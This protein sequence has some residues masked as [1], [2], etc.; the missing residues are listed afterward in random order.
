MGIVTGTLLRSPAT[1]F[2]PR[3]GHKDK[4]RLLS[5]ALVLFMLTKFRGCAPEYVYE[6]SLA[7]SN[8]QVANA[9]SSLHG[10][11]TLPSYV[12]TPFPMSLSY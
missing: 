2:T 4:V 12:V 3:I 8:L 11:A 5:M 7:K 9:V 10:I 1:E 6:T